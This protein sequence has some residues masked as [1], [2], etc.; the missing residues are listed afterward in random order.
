MFDSANN[1]MDNS[2]IQQKPLTLRKSPSFYVFSSDKPE[3]H[4]GSHMQ[5]IVVKGENNTEYENF[6]KFIKS[7]T[8]YNIELLNKPLKPSQLLK[9]KIQ[10]QH[11]H[12]KH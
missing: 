5:T 11:Y 8:N 6:I 3:K 7:E 9:K 4:K 1:N 12:D 10:R 2:E